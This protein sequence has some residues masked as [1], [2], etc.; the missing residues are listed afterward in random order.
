[1]ISLY[2]CM[3]NS[4]YERTATLGY[5]TVGIGGMNMIILFCIG[6]MIGAFFSLMLISKFNSSY[7][8]YHGCSY[9]DDMRDDAKV[10][11]TRK[12]DNNHASH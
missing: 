9:T 2:A 4:S 10:V 11:K 5:V 12:H 7:F 1:M 8:N 6:K 3:Q